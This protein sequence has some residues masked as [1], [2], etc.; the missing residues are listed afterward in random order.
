M[1]KTVLRPQNH[2]QK[3]FLMNLTEKSNDK[4]TIRNWFSVKQ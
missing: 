3:T 4:K 1:W 2:N